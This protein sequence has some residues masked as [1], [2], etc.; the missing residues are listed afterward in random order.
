MELQ[1]ITNEQLEEAKKIYCESF[2]KNN[3][4]TTF[5]FL[6]KIFGLFLGK[7][8]IGLVQVD[9]INDVFNNTKIAY[10][11]NFCIKMGYQNQGYG[12]LLLKKCIEQ[13]KNENVQTIQ[14]TCKK[15][16]IY[17][18]KLY[19]KYDFIPIDTVFLKKNI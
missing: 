15:N 2:N 19:Q 13:L 1:E 4:S 8:L 7:E 5:P 3:C 16:K 10:L 14:L 18:Q 6:G 11:N 17:A 9:F 12:E